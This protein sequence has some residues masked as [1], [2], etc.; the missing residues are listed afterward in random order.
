MFL[1]VPGRLEGLVAHVLGTLVRLL[2]RVCAQMA[3]QAIARGKGLAA[4]RGLTAVRPVPRV[5]SLVHL[6]KTQTQKQ[7]VRPLCGQQDPALVQPCHVIL[8]HTYY[9]EECGPHLKEHFCEDV[10]VYL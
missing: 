3:L 5:C 6:Y 1:Q 4:G 9:H 8:I 7:P 10:Y 2:P